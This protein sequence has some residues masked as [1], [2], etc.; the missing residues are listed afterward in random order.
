MSG[1]SITVLDNTVRVT[2]LVIARKDI[3]DYFRA[4]PAEELEAAFVRAVEV[5]IFCLERASTTRDTEFVRRQIEGLMAQVEK[6]PEDTQRALI[7]KLGTSEGQVL[8]P[9]KTLIDS[10]STTTGERLQ[11]VRKLLAD[12]IDPAKETSTL[13]RALQK[14]RDL[15]DPNRTDSVQY[16]IEKAVQD[17]VGADGALSRTVKSVVAE[18]V[19]PLATEVDRLTKEIRGERARPE[20]KGKLF[21]DE[22]VE[23]ATAWAQVVGA[24]VHH[25]G[26]DNAPGDVLIKALTDALA[27]NEFAVVIEARDR[28]EPVGRKVISEEIAQAMAERGANYGLYVS[29]GIDG[30]A[31]E[32]GEWAEGAC[33]RGPFVA[34]TYELLNIALRFAL[35]QQRLAALRAA[36]PEVDAATLEAQ[37]QRMRTALVRVATINRKVTDLHN[38]ARDIQ[39]EAEA[40]RKEVRDALMVIEQAIRA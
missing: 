27:P 24:E 16:T 18:A 40:L 33:D 10:V 34:C 8:A 15:L 5:G 21:E 6:I 1:G 19:T 22:V 17:V 23:A 31:K 38:S 12:E 20:I 35:V 3:A 25:V 37:V 28:Q 13:G 26:T 11:E 36:R 30:L 14:L 2:D 7:E 39:D 4:I 29:R 32:V 9:V